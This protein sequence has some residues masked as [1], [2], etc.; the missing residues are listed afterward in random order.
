MT[1][2]IWGHFGVANCS[3]DEHEM[4]YC[5]KMKQETG[6]LKLTIVANQQLLHS[7][8]HIST[9]SVILTER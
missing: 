9:T 8:M 7:Y 5:F 3:F 4:L 6:I 2:S 1:T